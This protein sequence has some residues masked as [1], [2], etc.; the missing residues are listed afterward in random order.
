MRRLFQIL[1]LTAVIVI[2]PLRSVM[3]FAAVT[4]A[5]IWWHLRT[6]DWITQH[7]A[8]PHNGIFTQHTERAWI[9]YSWG[10]EVTVS[11]VFHGFSANGLANLT[12]F[13]LT[14]HAVIAAVLFTCM[15]RISRRFYVSAVLTLIVLYASNAAAIRPMLFTILLYAVEL[16]LLLATERDGQARRLWWLAPLFLVWA[17]LHIQFV[18]GL[19][20]LGLFAL[21]MTVAQIGSRRTTRIP[22]GRIAAVT[23]WKVF[24]AAMVATC[25]GPYFTSVYATVFSYAGNTSQYRQIIE[26]A[27]INFRQ[28]Q[29]YVQLLL[30]L[31]AFFAIGWKHALDPFRM[32]LLV[33]T[34]LVAFRSQRD[35]WFVCIAA[36]LLLAE[37]LRPADEVSTGEA[38]G[39]RRPM[40]TATAFLL[41]VAIAGGVAVRRGMDPQTL[42]PVIDKQYPVRAASFVASHKLPGPMYNTFNW[43]GYLIFNLPD[44]PVSIDGRTDLFGPELDTRSMA[45]VNAY[46]LEHD[47]DFQRAHFVLLER[48]LPLASYLA[49]DPHYKLVYSDEISAV[50]V[51]TD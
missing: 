24:A 6:G 45:T 8:F 3:D 36:G 19:F 42:I 32:M 12:I 44:Y 10:F 48:M 13:L 27:A 28:P 18:Y 16:Y 23:A 30:V 43:G 14:L 40:V 21:A 46:A 20:V 15:E 17:N 37:A 50:F 22:P 4:D 11:R 49:S 5:D 34:A 7:A 33:S 47:A 31:A 39:R 41:A 38:R 9:A 29:H 1:L 51:K 2:V 25:I 26:F 35:A